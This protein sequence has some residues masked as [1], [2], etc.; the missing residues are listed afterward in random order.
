MKIAG[1]LADHMIGPALSPRDL[2]VLEKLYLG[3]TNRA[4]A[5]ALNI[6]ERS[7]AVYVSQVMSKMGAQTRQEAAAIAVRRGII[8]PQ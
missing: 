6:T 4:I 3:L 5:E 7:A 2:R 1:R 8:S